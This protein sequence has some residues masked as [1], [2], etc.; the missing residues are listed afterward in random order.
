MITLP[1]E[2]QLI[3]I[4]LAASLAVG[5]PVRLAGWRATLTAVG[6]AARFGRQYRF[7]IAAIALIGA[8]AGLWSFE[9]A[10]SA[11]FGGFS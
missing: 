6:L 7:W 10:R 9:A 1:A 4:A 3:A 11:L 8:A 5:L 2:V